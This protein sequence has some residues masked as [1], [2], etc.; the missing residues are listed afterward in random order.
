MALSTHA[1]I[2][3]SGVSVCAFEC[4]HSA[5][6]LPEAAVQTL[7][8]SIY[9]NKHCS[10]FLNRHLV[11][12][13]RLIYQYLFRMLKMLQCWAK[14][15]S[16]NSWVYAAR[17]HTD[18]DSDQIGWICKQF[19]LPILAFIVWQH[20]LVAVVMTG[21]KQEVRQSSLNSVNIRI[22]QVEGVHGSL[23]HVMHC[24]ITPCCHVM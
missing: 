10:R 11:L 7:D 3:P 17:P 18:N 1:Y 15:T 23:C 8:V 14:T 4:V 20:P 9:R 5:F 24:D 13:M 22:G 19:K 6:I 21:A 2:R 12:A 16:L